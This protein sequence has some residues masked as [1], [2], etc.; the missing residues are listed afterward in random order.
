[1]RELFEPYAVQNSNDDAAQ[2]FFALLGRLMQRWGLGGD[3]LRNDLFAGEHGMESVE[4]LRSLLELVQV[5]RG[6]RR[7]LA[8]F[9]ATP[10]DTALWRLLNGDSYPSFV[11]FR[12]S[13]ARH[14]DLYADRVLQER[15]LEPPPLEDNPPALIAMIRNHVR[16]RSRLDVL[17]DR[18]PEIRRRAERA[19]AARLRGHPLRR[20]VFRFVLAQARRTIKNRETLRLARSRAVGIFKRIYRH[21][22]RRFADQKLIGAARDIFYLTVGEIEGAIRGASVLGDLRELVALRRRDYE[23]FE[24]EAPPGRIV[25]R[26]IVH[27]A[28]LAGPPTAGASPVEEAPRRGE[29]ELRGIGCASGQVTARAMV[30]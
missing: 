10:D 12:R 2:Q 6:D 17:E 28:R 4:P 20:Q 16:A 22:G 24:T 14:I 19:V 26:G 21:I 5:V 30:V 1:M 13:L 23:R 9:H 18:E 8:L 27:G 15:K 11:E 7:L 25:V 29:D 3:D